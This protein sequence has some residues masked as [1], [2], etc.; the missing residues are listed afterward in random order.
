MNWNDWINFEKY[1]TEVLTLAFIG[2]VFWVAVYFFTIKN[3]IKHQWVE[4]PFYVACG[5]IVWEFLW[6]FIFYEQIDMGKLFVYSYRAWFFLDVYI[7]YAIYRYGNKQ[8]ENIHL[9]KHAKKL[10]VAITAM[11]LFILYAYIISGFDA[12]FGAQSAYILNL[13]ISTL[14]FTLWL[15]MRD[16]QPFSKVIAL[17][18]MIGT[19][20]YTIFFYIQFPENHFVPAI[21]LVIF[22]IDSFYCYLIFS[23]KSPEVSQT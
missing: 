1:D 16:E 19:A 10:I 7:F 11:W 14:Y 22:I 9:R 8:I 18:K 6:G 13:G 23:Y 15:R 17:C 21:G 4:M 5:N 20:I 3:I 2:A 12:P